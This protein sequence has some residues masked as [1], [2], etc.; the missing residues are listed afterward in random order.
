MSLYNLLFGQHSNASDLL[1][2]LGITEHDVPRYRSCY[3][4]GTHIVIHTRTGGGNRDFYENE[5]SC[6]DNYPEYFEGE[7]PPSG[8]WN[9]DLRAISGYVEDR[10]DDFD[11]TYAD[12]FYEPP[13]EALEA[14][15]NVPADMS[16]TDQWNA[17]WKALET[18]K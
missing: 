7:E 5:E 3:W 12:F 2:L 15:K 9:D 11:C 10:D 13:S 14:L 6:R 16:P 4:N 1:K 8:P 18:N 17:L